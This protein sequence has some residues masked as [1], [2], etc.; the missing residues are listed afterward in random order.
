MSLNTANHDPAEIE[1]FNHGLEHWW[2]VDG[3]LKTLHRI[4][5]PRLDFIEQFVSLAGKTVLD[6]GCGG[7]ILS[8]AL[9]ER[10]SSVTGVDQS[11]GALAAAQQHAESRHINNTEYLLQTAEEHAQH[12]P[13]EYDVI[14][15]M[16]M[17]E[18]VPEPE[19]IIQACAQLLKPGG[20]AFFSTL[21]RNPLA[22]LGAVVAA[23]HILRFIPQGTHQYEKFI[24]PSEL[25]RACR[26]EGLNLEGSSGLGYLPGIDKAYLSNNL[27]INYLI[28]VTKPGE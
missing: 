17:L 20:M 15:C 11:P 10:A 12:H 24:K 4:N 8:E 26:H 2:D 13:A 5:P 27:S 7:G 22:Y 6:V 21:N 23:E 9:A 16:E 14:T 1:K 19:S 25:V 28:A 18:H 3:P